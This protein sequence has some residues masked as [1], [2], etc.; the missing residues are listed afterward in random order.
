VCPSNADFHQ[1]DWGNRQ[2]EEYSKSTDEAIQSSEFE[3]QKLKVELNH[4]FDRL[5]EARDNC[6][7]RQTQIEKLSQLV[8]PVEHDITYIVRD[9]SNK[10]KSSKIT[11]SSRNSAKQ[12]NSSSAISQ[13]AINELCTKPSSSVYSKFVKDGEVYELERNLEEITKRVASLTSS[14][15]I[16]LVQADDYSR[17]IV[18]DFHDELSEEKLQ[19]AT[20][21]DEV[22]KLDY[23]CF[24]SASELLR[25]RLSI[26]IS[27]REELEEIAQL[28]REKEHYKQKER[29]LQHQLSSEINLVKQK[30]DAELHQIKS[31]FSGQFK[32]LE[33]KM[34]R[35]DKRKRKLTKLKTGEKM[36]SLT[37]NIALSKDKYEKLKKRNALELEGYQSEINLLNQRL[38]QLRLKQEQSQRMRAMDS[39]PRRLR[40]RDDVIAHASK[41]SQ[42]VLSQLK[43]SMDRLR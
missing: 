25:L 39:K 23:E 21:S 42:H 11:P 33:D 38:K 37:E 6:N 19:A 2:Q 1:F 22:D 10:P 13:E 7:I 5:A 41:S 4:S 12:L 35:L 27:Q 26:F 14:F 9:V 8:Q 43:S 36:K 17:S 30:V 20:L 24:L 28:N 16:S 32:S 18:K 34:A 15:M 31:N 3:Y 29:E 40:G